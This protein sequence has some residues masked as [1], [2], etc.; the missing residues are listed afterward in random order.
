MAF[1]DR[2]VEHPGRYTLTNADTGTVLGT[3][4]LVR[5]EGEVTEPGTLLNANN[6]N[7]PDISSLSIGGES[8]ADWVIETGTDNSWNYKK[9]HSGKYEA[10]RYYQANSLVITTAS[11]GTYYGGE[12]SI[13]FP[14]FHQSL[15]SCTYGSTKSQSSGVF[16]YGTE[17]SGSNLIVHYRAHASINNAV[18]GGF[19]YIHGTY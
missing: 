3:F 7:N 10:W 19:F 17:A 18:C 13:P 12:K 16:I 11:A 9:W 4:D 1:V 8:I 2:I 6:L 5:A 14:S 15:E